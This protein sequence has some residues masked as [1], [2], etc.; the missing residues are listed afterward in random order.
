MDSF[1]ICIPL[2]PFKDVGK[3]LMFPEVSVLELTEP[4]VHFTVCG[5]QEPGL[6]WRRHVAGSEAAVGQCLC[7]LLSS[8][9]AA[10][11]L[12][13]LRLPGVTSMAQSCTHCSMGASHGRVSYN[14]LWPSRLCTFLWAPHIRARAAEFLSQ[15]I[16]AVDDVPVVTQAWEVLWLKTQ[17][18][19]DISPIMACER[20]SLSKLDKN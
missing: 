15:Q 8:D 4:R 10:R 14:Q 9:L 3:W 18:N 2:K 12:A 13:P 5:F 16:T 6:P 7:P 17:H 19:C 1:W 20:Y 11:P